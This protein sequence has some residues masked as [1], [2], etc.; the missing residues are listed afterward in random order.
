MIE[1][2]KGLCAETIEKFKTLKCD[3]INTEPL[4]C[5]VENITKDGIIMFDKWKLQ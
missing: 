1:K 5:Y 3:E 2:V 4:V